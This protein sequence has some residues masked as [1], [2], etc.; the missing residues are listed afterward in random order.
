M[1]KENQTTVNTWAQESFGTPTLRVSFDRFVEEVAELGNAIDRV[2]ANEGDDGDVIKARSE[3]ADALITLYRVAHLLGCDLDDEVDRKMVINR[4]RKW[5]ATGQG[6]GYH[7]KD[8][9]TP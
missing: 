4:A 8:G 3:C 1:A 9:G 7:V 2:G 6:T 5:R